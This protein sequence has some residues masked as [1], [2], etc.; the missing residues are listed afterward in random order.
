MTKSTRRT[1]K[2][3]AEAHRGTQRHAKAH[4][5]T[6]GG[7]PDGTPGGTP[8]KP[9][10]NANSVVFRKRNKGSTG[11]RE[12]GKADNADAQG[13]PRWASPAGMDA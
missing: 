1:R 4:K 7:T 8:G 6:K 2:R 12:N 5:G 10:Q 13:Q 3:H 11:K 9:K